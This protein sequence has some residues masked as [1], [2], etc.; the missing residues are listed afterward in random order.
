MTEEANMCTVLCYVSEPVCIWTH[1]IGKDMYLGHV[2][3]TYVVSQ[4]WHL[5]SLVICW[6]GNHSVMLCPVAAMSGIIL[7]AAEED[8]GPVLVY[9]LM[10]VVLCWQVDLGWTA[11]WVKMASQWCC[12]ALYIWTLLAPRILRNRDFTDRPAGTTS[13]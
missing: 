5:Y 8:D 3:L 10:V 11:V 7:Q 1:G 6:T 12:I 9:C 2:I 13:K 4:H